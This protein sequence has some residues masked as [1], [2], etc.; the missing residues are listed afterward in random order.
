MRSGK[1]TAAAYLADH[2]QLHQYA[3]GE[4]LKVMLKSVFGDHFH[5]GDRSGICPEAGV[6]YRHLMQTLG[7]EW[8][9]HQV[10]PNLWVNLVS[11]RWH[12]VKNRMG[13]PHANGMVLSDVRFDSEA[14]WILANGGYLLEI[15]RQ[16]AEGD[17]AHES[18]AGID[19]DFPRYAIDND[20][21]LE[22]LYDHLS[23]VVR[24]LQ[25]AEAVDGC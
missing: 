4:P 22:E 25:P 14:Q 2:L 3:F 7:T 12:H 16:S 15:R 13:F 23:R 24:V 20:G 19:L 8:A 17:A 10:N 11:K 21:T 6:S 9:R 1:D 5:H 18:E